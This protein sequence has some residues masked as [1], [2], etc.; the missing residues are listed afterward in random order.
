MW[1]GIGGMVTIAFH[2]NVLVVK[3]GGESKAGTFL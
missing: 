1:I 3:V 2:E